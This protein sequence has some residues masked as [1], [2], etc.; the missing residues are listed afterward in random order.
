VSGCVVAYD[1]K[2]S[3]TWRVKYA[4]ADG[5]QTMETVGAERDGVTRKHA[6]AELRERLVRVD[7]TGYRRPKPLTF[8]Q[9]SKDWFHEQQTEKGWKASTE[10][11]YRSILGRLDDAF[12]PLQLADVR[13]TDVTAYKTRMLANGYS[14]ASVSRDISIL[15]SL[16]AWA[17]VTE[18]IDRNAAAGCRIRSGRSG[19][20]TRSP[21]RRCRRSPGRSSTNRTRSCS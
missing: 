13:P 14:G 9:A 7:R 20:G 5:K 2:R 10:T 4:D 12:G 1:G 3:R 21:R 18:R 16:L 17:V 15:H 11:Q 6:E 8:A 19:R